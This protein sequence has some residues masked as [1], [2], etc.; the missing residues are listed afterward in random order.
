MTEHFTPETMIAL[1]A[2]TQP[3][4]AV[5]QRPVLSLLWVLDPNTGRPV[6]QWVI[7]SSQVLP[8]GRIQA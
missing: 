7:N 2:S 8:G 5:V 6:G 3:P 4:E 1:G